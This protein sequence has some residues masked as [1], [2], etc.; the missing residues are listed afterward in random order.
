MT[1][2]YKR[3]DIIVLQKTG[4]YRPHRLVMKICLFAHHLV[5]T[6]KIKKWVDIQDCS[7]RCSHHNGTII[8]KI[9]TNADSMDQ[10]GRYPDC[11]GNFSGPTCLCIQLPVIFGCCWCTSRPQLEVR[12]K[13]NL[14]NTAIWLFLYFGETSLDLYMLNRKISFISAPAD[15][16]Y[17]VQLIH[18]HSSNNR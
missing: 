3:H 18:I 17:N 1:I 13:E 7:P 10:S 6:A 2:F 15:H 5:L 4:D 8:K 9:R 14:I 11:Y 12:I 16:T